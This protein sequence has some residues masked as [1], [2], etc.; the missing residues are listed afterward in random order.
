MS[1]Q[2]LF[3]IK[4]DI[5]IANINK[6]M[7]E[8]ETYRFNSN[9]DWFAKT[10]LELNRKIINPEWPKNKTVPTKG[11]FINW[12]IAELMER[13]ELVDSFD[14][15]HWGKTDI[16]AYCMVFKDLDNIKIEYVD[17]LN[18]IMSKYLNVVCDVEKH[19][20]NAITLRKFDFVPKFE[21]LVSNIN[22]LSNP[23]TVESILEDLNRELEFLLTIKSPTESI[24]SLHNIYCHL[25]LNSVINYTVY[26]ENKEPH[27]GD[28]IEVSLVRIAEKATLWNDN[29]MRLYCGKLALN[30]LRAE[31]NYKRE[32]NSASLK[33]ITVNGT[34]L[35]LSLL[36]QDSKT[37]TD[38]ELLHTLLKYMLLPSGTRVHPLS[39]LHRDVYVTLR[40]IMSE[41]SK[42]Q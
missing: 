19:G 42:D 14:W 1:T 6:A 16:T 9:F 20:V 28:T 40:D 21:Y 4:E 33:G 35:D 27:D 15:K 26:A 3:R 38:N 2:Q 5:T 10:Q 12:E 11:R 24:V 41:L 39:S 36:F 34:K 18:F 8:A 23:G 31:P 22:K 30:S 37:V 25:V 13:A 29:L 32:F 17:I 7:G